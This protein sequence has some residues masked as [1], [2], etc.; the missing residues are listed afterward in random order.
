M[1]IK[2]R[3]NAFFIHLSISLLLAAI[4]LTIVLL[5]WYPNGMIYAGGLEGLKLIVGVDLVLGPVLTFIVFDL[6]KPELKRDITLIGCLQLSCMGFGTWIVYTERPVAQVLM[7]DGVHLIS[8]A[9]SQDYD[10]KLSSYPGKNVKRII[11]N[12]PEN[13]KDWKT[14]QSLSEFVDAIPYLFRSDLYIGLD[15][16]DEDVYKKRI[17]QIKEFHSDE[18]QVE[19]APMGGINGCDWIPLRSKHFKGL[20][21]FSKKN[22]VQKLNNTRLL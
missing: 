8:L 17:S 21:C 22:G 7:G 16:V 19:L 5:Q 11:M 4:L 15:K 6:A 9:E 1:T 14:A 10:L 18:L 20:A 3:L 2:P 13:P 12:L